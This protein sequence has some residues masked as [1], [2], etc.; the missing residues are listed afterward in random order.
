MARTYNIALIYIIVL[1]VILFVFIICKNEL[2][3]YK[4]VKFP[5]IMITNKVLPITS[6][7]MSDLLVILDALENNIPFGFAHFNDGEIMAMNYRE[8]FKTVYDWM[9]DSSTLL[10]DSMQKA[11]LNTADNFYIGIPCNCEFRGFAFLSALRYLNISH[12]L[13]Y[14][15]TVDIKSS[16]KEHYD[17]YHQPKSDDDACP[18][19]PTTLVFPNKKLK[20]RITVST[21][22]INGNYVRAKKELIRI[23]SIVCINQGRMVHVVTAYNRTIKNLPFPVKSVQYIA[24]KNAFQINYENFRTYEFLVKANYKSGDVVLIMAGPLG[25]YLHI[26][27]YKYI[28]IYKYTYIY[29]NIQR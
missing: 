1:I 15:L 2:S 26:Y 18:I 4:Y 28:S 25:K 8:G 9:Q 7:S 3:S 29:K 27:K 22:F 23:L 14:H 20:N 12:N 19:T 21:L 17:Q 16:T 11:L 5:T 6:N 10:A 13:P 24:K